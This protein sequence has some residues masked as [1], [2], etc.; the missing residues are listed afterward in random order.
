MDLGA[1]GCINP[2]GYAGLQ[3]IDLASIGVVVPWIEAAQV[4]TTHL[5]QRLTLD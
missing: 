3:T 1:F 4:L 2:C 5:V